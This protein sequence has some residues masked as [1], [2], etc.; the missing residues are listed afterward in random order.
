M[1]EKLIFRGTLKHG[2]C[3]DLLVLVLVDPQ[4]PYD[5]SKL[6]KCDGNF[7]AAFD[8]E[9]QGD[10]SACAKPHV[11]FKTKVPL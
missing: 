10:H 8:M 7:S 2:I 3:F 4:A 1:V 11:D 6:F 5:S 9:I